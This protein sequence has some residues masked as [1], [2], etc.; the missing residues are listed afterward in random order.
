MDDLKKVGVIIL[1]YNNNKDTINCIRSVEQYN[2]V[3]IKI[4]VVDNGSTKESSISKL[5][6]YFIRHYP[7]NYRL[8]TETDEFSTLPYISFLVSKSN[9][10]YAKGNNKGL[11]LAYRDTEIDKILILNSDILFVEDILPP[12]INDLENL[13]NAGIVSPLLY[14]KDLV[15]IDYNCCRKEA[16]LSEIFITYMFLFIDF[17]GLLSK[18]RKKRILYQ[19]SSQHLENHIIEIELPSGS[20]MLLQKEL[21]KKLGSFDPHTFL[22]YEE[23]ILY[24]KIKKL[25]L[26]NYL[27]TNLKCIHLGATT[28]KDAPSKFILKCGFDSAYYYLSN[29]TQASFLYLNALKFFF[30]ILMLKLKIQS[31]I[32]RKQTF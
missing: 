6:S 8:I 26:K 17:G 13:P 28:T 22:Y 9:D 29:Y 12:L 20:C 31:L 27:D 5:D 23:D 16:S 18:L 11:S 25:K 4:I 2:S 3:K 10:G 19:D 30:K 14:K 1:N 21:F 15:G 32:N 7:G 24:Q